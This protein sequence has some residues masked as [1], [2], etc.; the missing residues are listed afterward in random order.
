MTEID[1]EA[2]DPGVPGP[3]VTVAV[4]P[5]ADAVGHG[6]TLPLVGG[7]RPHVYDVVFD[8]G[9]RR[10][11]ADTVDD[12][13]SAFIPG[14]AALIAAGI[15]ADAAGDRDAMEEALAQIFEARHA[16]ANDLRVRLQARVNQDARASGTWDT[17]DEEERE[18]LDRSAEGLIPVGVLYEVPLENPDGS[19]VIVDKGFWTHATIPLVINRGDYELFDP[20]FTPEPESLLSEVD[21]ETGKDIVYGGR[22]PVNLVIL[23]PT[24]SDAY[25]ESLEHAGEVTVSLR[26]VDLPDD[27]YLRAVE[28]GRELLHA[29]TDLSD[30]DGAAGDAGSPGEDADE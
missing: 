8:A 26:P 6:R 20:N 5:A 18:Q 17:L 7:Q 16:H 2:A 1:V 28:T 12:V 25:L 9:T 21:P 15:E 13:L 19:E 11:Y 30:G 27:L 29:E 23:D 3:P 10:V 24:D 22:W 4:N 14:Y